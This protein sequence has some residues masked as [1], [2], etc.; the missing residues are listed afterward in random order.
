MQITI[1]QGGP[2]PPSNVVTVTGAS[3][4][5]FNGQYEISAGVTVTFASAEAHA[6]SWAW[7]FG[8]GDTGSGQTATHAFR[9]AG[10]ETVTLTVTGD[11]TTNQGTNT[12]QIRFSV[13]PP[14]F[15]A[16]M[17][18]G[19]GS[20]LA[21]SGNWATDLS[22]TNPGTQPVTITLYFAAFS[23]DIPSDLSTLQ[24]DSL[25]SVPLDGGQSWSGIDVVG[26]ADDPRTGRGAGKGILLLK[27][28]GGNA[29]PIVTA[30]VYFT[31]QGS[32]F[33]TALPSFV[34]GPFGAAQAQEAEAA[35]GRC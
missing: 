8:D 24:F 14:S 35:T 6:A 7:D 19:A 18:P 27:F 28:E 1:T 5:P 25:K 23:D 15:Q 11:G 26:D 30:R 9:A 17:I 2:P 20:I 21:D 13:S 32:S 31:A 22:V 34:V 33:G 16:I 12:T 10:T 3:I 4:N 29:T